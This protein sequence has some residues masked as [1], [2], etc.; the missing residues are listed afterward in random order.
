LSDECCAGNV[1]FLPLV[2]KLFC[3]HLVFKIPRFCK[4]FVDYY[5]LVIPQQLPQ[6]LEAF[7]SVF[8]YLHFLSEQVCG[9]YS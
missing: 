7:H 3:Q 6:V 5:C 4:M 9:L 8:L 2:F 1:G